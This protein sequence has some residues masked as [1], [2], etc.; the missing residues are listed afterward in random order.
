MATD[1]DPEHSTPGAD[2]GGPRRPAA[3]SGRRT[4]VLLA[5]GLVLFGAAVGA[6]VASVVGGS[7]S[8]TAAASES[9][10]RIRPPL[11]APAA[12]RQPQLVRHSPPVEVSIPKIDVSSSLVGLRLETNG[13]LQVPTDYDQAGWYVSGPA[14]GDR[15]PAVVVGHVDSKAGPAV[16]YRLRELKPGDTT[17]IRRSDGT[18]TTFAVDKTIRVAKDDFPTTEVYGPTTRPELRLITCDGDIDESTGHYRDNFVVFLHEQ[19]AAA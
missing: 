18:T 14:P 3:F 15:G 19:G 11:P 1:L 12:G 10:A 9:T 16:F 13:E 8:G 7:D 5:A 17:E 4:I 2:P 6:G